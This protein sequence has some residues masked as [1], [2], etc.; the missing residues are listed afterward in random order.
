MD[1]AKVYFSPR[2]AY[3][4]YR[5]ARNV[6]PA[7][8]VI[9]MFAGVGPF[10]IMISK[11]SEATKIYAIDLNPSA[12]EYLNKNIVRNKVENVIPL[13]GNASELLPKLEPADRIIMNLPHTSSEFIKL[14]VQ[15]LNMGG[16]I[17]YYE[18][19]P[20]ETIDTR[21]TELET[22]TDNSTGKLTKLKLLSTRVVHN[23]SPR[24]V[25]VCFDLVKIV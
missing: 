10:S 16:I 25:Q 11:Y 14:A 15:K 8:I 22:I 23:Y 7:E 21:C 18:I 9:D 12:I 17:H 13:E 4:H 1:L 5:I 2:L 6:K 20:R 3:E 24:D 19:L